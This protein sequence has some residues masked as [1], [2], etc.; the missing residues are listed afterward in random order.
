MWV[1]M[2]NL[3]IHCPSWL[4]WRRIESNS[5]NSQLLIV[6]IYLICLSTTSRLSSKYMKF[7][8]LNRHSSNLKFSRT[9]LTQSNFMR[10]QQDQALVWMIQLRWQLGRDSQLTKL[11]MLWCNINSHQWLVVL[12]NRALTSVPCPKDLNWTRSVTVSL[13]AITLA[14]S[15]SA[16]W[17][18]N[19][20][21]CRAFSL[22]SHQTPRVTSKSF[23]TRRCS[24][25][26]TEALRWCSRLE[27]ICS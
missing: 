10:Y 19:R 20:P 3:R 15:K 6:V 16:N 1:A 22:Q 11:V 8:S 21:L 2:H 27:V 13:L 23:A 17:T 24:K 18:I 14:A 4:I 26:P 25:Q 5:R 9:H 12:S 7:S